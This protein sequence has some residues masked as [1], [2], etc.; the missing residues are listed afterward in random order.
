MA[1]DEQHLLLA[2]GGTMP[3]NEV[4]TNT[5]RMRYVFAELKPTQ[6]TVAGWLAGGFKDSLA[7]F[8][9]GVKGI[10]GPG[11]KLAWMKA[12]RVGVDGKYTDPTTNLYTW[13]API[14][15][16]APSDPPNQSALAISTKTAIARGRAHIGR[17]FLPATQVALEA[18]TGAMTLA[19]AQ[20]IATFAAAYINNLNNA[21]D[22]ATIDQCKCAVFSNIGA[23]DHQDITGI[24]VGR[25]VD[26]QR[27]RRNKTVEAGASANLP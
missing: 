23:G 5:L 16:T 10:V 20:N 18:T 12:N 17:F 3:G 11:T 7:T 1:Y 4:W 21:T 26:T 15:G 24:R 6:E 27:R 2:W 13:A 14:A 19:T 25:V 8:W 22:L 9:T